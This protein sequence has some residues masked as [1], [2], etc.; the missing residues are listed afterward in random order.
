MNEN[1]IPA[2]RDRRL[3]REKHPISEASARG[4]REGHSQREGTGKFLRG[5]LGEAALTWD[6]YPIKQNGTCHHHL[7]YLGPVS[8]P[9][10]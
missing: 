7:L 8:L 6:C 9:R 10:C 2:K 5:R 1:S 4:Q 3:A